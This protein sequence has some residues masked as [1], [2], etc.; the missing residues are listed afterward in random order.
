MSDV[1][2]FEQ[3]V[4]LSLE[5]LEQRKSYGVLRLCIGYCNPHTFR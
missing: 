1:M 4:S 3:I 5:E 2:S